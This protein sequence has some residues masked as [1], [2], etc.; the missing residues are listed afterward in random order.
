[1]LAEMQAANPGEDAGYEELLQWEAA[2]GSVSTGLSAEEL[3]QLK[4]RT[5]EAEAEDDDGPHCA[6]CCCEFVAG[7][8]LMQLACGHEFHYECVATWLR[9]KR[10]CPMCKA[11]V[12][13]G[14]HGPVPMDDE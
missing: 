6:I 12:G 8:R 9:A 3:T 5:V 13:P 1:M 2:Q 14:G 4:A 7:D 11:T 10:V